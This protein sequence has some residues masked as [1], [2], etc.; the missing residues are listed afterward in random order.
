MN[1]IKQ[2]ILITLA[3]FS[4]LSIQQADAVQYEATEVARIKI[5]NVDN[6][7]NLIPTGG[8]FSG[9]NTLEA[10]GI[11][12]N[13]IS[14]GREG[15]DQ[16]VRAA[17]IFLSNA[18]TVSF[19]AGNLLSSSNTPTEWIYDADGVGT[20]FLIADSNKTLFAGYFT[21][22]STLL[23]EENGQYSYSGQGVITEIDGVIADHFG[24][25]NLPALSGSSFDIGNIFLQGISLN[26]DGSY[27][28]EVSNNDILLRSFI[29]ELV[30]E[31]TPVNTPSSGA[32]ISMLGLGLFLIRFVF[33]NLLTKNK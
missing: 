11:G 1:Q 17:D 21:G 25:G 24:I 32:T 2:K 8:T 22:T 31:N 6:S 5:D 26:E 15:V 16:S 23:G 14:D 20:K 30:D 33:G 4:L 7:G 27:T 19:S 10:S 18:T 3:T 13:R 29:F 9:G 28:G 12:V